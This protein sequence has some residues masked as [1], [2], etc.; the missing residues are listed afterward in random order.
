MNIH[1]EYEKLLHKNLKHAYLDE[2]GLEDYEERIKR[3]LVRDVGKQISTIIT[4]N[5]RIRGKTILE[6]GAGWGEIAVELAIKGAV[7]IGI[8]PDEEKIEISRLLAKIKEQDVKFVKGVGEELPY[9]DN[10]FEFVVC[11]TVLEHVD[12][13]KKVLSEMIRVLKEDGVLYLN[14]PNYLIPYER[15]YKTFY[16]AMFPKPLVKF[17]L[18]MID[19]PTQFIDHIKYITQRFVSKELKKYPVRTRNIW[20]EKFEKELKDYGLPERIAGKIILALGIDLSI[21]LF[22]TKLTS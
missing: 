22:I 18:R 9:P 7:V 14:T 15:H 6:V 4:R 11:S 13:P 21:E 17:Y 3:R 10:H 19:R 5:F 2:L 1:E 12:K 16:P 8:E 20:R